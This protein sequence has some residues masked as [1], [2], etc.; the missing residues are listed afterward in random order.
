MRLYVINTL[1]LKACIGVCSD[2]DID[3]ILLKVNQL[4]CLEQGLNRVYIISSSKK[5]T[6]YFY[7]T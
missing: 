3:L 7:K 1:Y 5:K 2:I 6:W 4:V